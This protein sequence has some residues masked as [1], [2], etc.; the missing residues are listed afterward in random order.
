MSVS[1]L[2]K[3]HIRIR[4]I[5]EDEGLFLQVASEDEPEDSR[6]GLMPCDPDVLCSVL[7]GLTYQLSSKDTYCVIR[8]SGSMID[9]EYQRGS[10]RH[11]CS[12]EAEEFARLVAPAMPARLRAMLL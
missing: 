4:L 7:R 5:R 1:E 8:R 6:T 11:K 9:I 2:C 10:D 3:D 12:L